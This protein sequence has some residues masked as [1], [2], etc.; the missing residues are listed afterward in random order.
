M[1]YFFV[2][3]VLF[4]FGLMLRNIKFFLLSPVYLFSVFTIISIVLSFW[5]Y[6]SYENKFNL[7][8]LDIVKEKEFINVM[9]LYL[10]SFLFFILGVLF[11]HNFSSKT[12]RFFFRK[13]YLAIL[14]FKFN[15]PKFLVLLSKVLF[16]VL[17]VLYMKT[18][19]VGIFFRE[20]YLSP[21][22][23]KAL[24]LVLKVLTLILSIF[25]GLTYY[26]NK[27]SNYFMFLILIILSL[28]TGS[29]VTIIYLIIFYVLL[30][31]SR[32]NNN[33]NKV[34]FFFNGFAVLIILSLLISFRKYESHGIGPYLMGIVTNEDDTL[35]EFFRNFIF[36][37]Y[38]SFIFGVFA[39][40]KTLKEAIPDWS[41]IWVS[42]NPL[43]GTVAGF[44]K[45]VPNL[46]LNPFAPFTSHGQVFV[47][48]K[49][50][51]SLFYFVVGVLFT[52][53]DYRIRKSFHHKKIIFAFVLIFLSS[54]YIVY[55]FEY[56]LRSAVRYLYYIYF[57]ILL[58]W[59]TK[60]IFKILPRKSK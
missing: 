38:Y 52:D 16:F 2:F 34:R 33:L 36:N 28:G 26:N 59:L 54:L 43:P 7:Y 12:K 42:L 22:H 39:T 55:S 10:Y 14:F 27:A 41:I 46:M 11:Y 23:P 58:A 45:Y 19:G 60:D 4:F 21:E 49:G 3:C 57:L 5:Y 15:Y 8:S 29:R 1:I 31:L 17:I 32:G 44:Y 18:Y 40:I 37:I 48:G 35:T 20:L 50:F 47:M 56:L 25:L 9:S 6:Y 51:T 24:Q 13:S 30:F 53:I